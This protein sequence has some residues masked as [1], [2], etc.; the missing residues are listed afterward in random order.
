MAIFKIVD[1]S[2]IGSGGCSGRRA[3]GFEREGLVGDGEKCDA[4]EF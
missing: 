1:K 3:G 4:V 2:G